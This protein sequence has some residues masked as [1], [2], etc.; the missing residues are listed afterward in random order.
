[1]GRGIENITDAC[2]EAGQREP[3]FGFK[4]DREFSVTFFSD[5]AIVAKDT[6]GDGIKDGLSDVQKKYL[7]CSRAI[8]A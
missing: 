6:N 4:H 7:C 2:K 3:S 5:V 8:R 1:L